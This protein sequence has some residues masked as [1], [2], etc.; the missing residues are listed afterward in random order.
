M[1]FSNL[2]V[3]Q[4]STLAAGRGNMSFS[5]FEVGWNRPLEL[6][7]QPKLGIHRISKKRQDLQGFPLDSPDF[8]GKC[9]TTPTHIGPDFMKS[10]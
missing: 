3:V 10:V 8:S 2:E 5:N 6:I 7:L 9:P 1:S 4:E